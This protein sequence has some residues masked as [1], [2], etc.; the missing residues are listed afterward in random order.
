M[1]HRLIITI[2]VLAVPTSQLTAG[3]IRTEKIVEDMAAERD[4]ISA[5]LEREDVQ[6]K[7]VE[8]GVDPAEADSRVAALTDREVAQ[9]A[10]KLDQLP[11]GADGIYIGL[12]TLILIAILVFLIFRR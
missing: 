12:G 10:G 1:F 3:M 8:L 4:R 11:A 6:K 2:L 9:I 7:L 5:F